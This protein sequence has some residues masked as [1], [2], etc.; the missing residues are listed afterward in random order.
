MFCQAAALALARSFTPSR[1]SGRRSVLFRTTV[2]L[3]DRPPPPSP[4][5]PFSPPQVQPPRRKPPSPH[6]A[7]PAQ[8]TTSRAQAAQATRHK[9]PWSQTPRLLFRVAARRRNAGLARRAVLLRSAAAR[10]AAYAAAQVPAMGANTMV[11]AHVIA[12]KRL[13]GFILFTPEWCGGVNGER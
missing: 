3:T 9:P 4:P 10:C 8:Q 13:L 12:D 5:Q 7:S 11:L 6:R 2:I 1:T